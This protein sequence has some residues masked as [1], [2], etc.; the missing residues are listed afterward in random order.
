M[1]EADAASLSPLGRHPCVLRRD[2]GGGARGRVALASRDRR[3]DRHGRGLVRDPRHGGRGRAGYACGWSRS[4]A[5]ARGAAVGP[6]RLRR[7]SDFTSR[8]HRRGPSARASCSSSP[9]RHRRVAA[10]RADRFRWRPVP[11]I[12]LGLALLAGTALG[13]AHTFAKFRT[14]LPVEPRIR[15]RATCSTPV[16]VLIAATWT[17]RG[18]SRRSRRRLWGRVVGALVALAEYAVTRDDLEG[19][20]AWVGRWKDF[21]ARLAGSSRRRTRFRRSSSCRP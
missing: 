3:R 8:Q 1:A 20:L 5:C 18:G 19:P 21:G 14:G 13:V 17:A 11:A 15:D 10:G 12:W 9:A 16:V 6:R 7:D 2:L 4:G